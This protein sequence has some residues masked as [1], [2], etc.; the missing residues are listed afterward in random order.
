MV[1]RKQG[2]QKPVLWQQNA[3]LWFCTE[4][5]QLKVKIAKIVVLV[6]L[7]A[8]LGIQFVPTTRNQSDIEPITDIMQVFDTP[9]QVPCCWDK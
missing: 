8:F 3:Q 2:N 1:K 6:L 5:N 4:G 7:V 9:P